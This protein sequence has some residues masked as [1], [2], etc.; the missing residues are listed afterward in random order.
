MHRFA[1]V[2]PSAPLVRHVLRG[3]QWA[4]ALAAVLAVIPAAAADH[5]GIHLCRIA[6]PD[7]IVM[8]VELFGYELDEARAVQRRGYDA[9]LA[10]WQAGAREWA[11]IV[12][13]EEYPVPKPVE[14]QVEVLEELTGRS[15][16][17]RAAARDRRR[18]EVERWNACTV[19]DLHGHAAA[20]VIRADQVAA[21]MHQE[22]DCFARAMVRWAEAR[23]RGGEELAGRSPVTP[24]LVTLAEGLATAAEAQP[25]VDEANAALAAAREQAGTPAPDAN[26]ASGFKAA[27]TRWPGFV[28]IYHGSN[29]NA[30]E[31]FVTAIKEAH[32]AASGCAEWQVEQCAKRGLNA[33]AFLWAHE[34][35][36]VPA[37]FRNDDTVL[38][39]YLGDRI[40]PSKW[41]AWAGLEAAA[42]A[43]DPFHPAVFSMSPQSWGGID[44][45]FPVVRGRAVEY[46]HYH[47]DGNRKPQDHF[48]YLELYRQQS[49]AHGDLPIVRLLE[50]RVED[51]RKT[52]QTV[53]TS[54]AYGVR[55][56]Q[57][58]GGLFDGNQRDARGV[59]TPN[60]FGKAAAR[61]N[62]AVA[63]F[64][65]ALRR[66]RNLDV[67]Q[68]AP[69]PPWGREAPAG[70]W[71]RPE[72][73]DVVLGEFTDRYDRYLVLANRDAFNPH[74]ATLRFT[75]DGLQV[76]RVDVESGSWQDLTAARGDGG[77]STVTVPLEAGGGALV[78]VVGHRDPPEISAPAEFVGQ[79]LVR[80]A[81]ANP[82]DTIRYTLDGSAPT[83]R[84]PA[85]AG[86]VEIGA[87]ATV[88]AIT[89]NA[90]GGTS[91]AA[92]AAC[93]RVEPKTV[94]GKQLGPGIAYDSYEGAWTK[95]PDFAALQPVGRGVRSDI[96][97][98]AS[99]RI[100]NFALRFRG[101]FEIA[102]G[103][104]HTFTL[105]SDDGSRLVIDGETVLDNDGV[106]GVVTQNKTVELAPGWHA[107]ELVY[108]QGVGGSGLSLSCT[109]PDGK[110]LP[111]TFW[112]AP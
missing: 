86:P 88:R 1:T 76:S 20:R 52:G 4:A 36:T 31:T 57:Y 44:L 85:Y 102:Q 47:W 70:H 3:A 43:A 27:R 65:P 28:T 18:A 82:R 71:V 94:A 106:H 13:Q 46:Y 111:L 77:G 32:Y 30:D 60:D 45:Y 89:V 23:A 41:G 38:C 33:F 112:C 15:D 62:K 8:T 26:P 95:L 110:P 109:G 51:M 39:Y 78:R 68:T 64:A 14:P 101:H 42:Y 66:C 58:G 87:T 100:D 5:G 83:E 73:S 98:A 108:F 17:E 80:M 2:V 24:K 22:L 29:W 105:G 21:A 72:G 81:A 92:E 61:I 12:K 54:L 67:F 53:F 90:R 35:G 96:A 91:A 6:R 104:G 48:V 99:R 55:G 10:D 7:G 49:A 16:E 75:E 79:A 34:A 40:K 11:D 25:K 74:D 84:S 97:L 56:F 103:G 107:L 50:S 19:G 69:L 37:K 63:A 93:T 59:P 9:A